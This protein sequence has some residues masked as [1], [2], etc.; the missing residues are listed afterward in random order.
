V[1]RLIIEDFADVSS[2]TPRQ[3]GG[4]P[5]TAISIAAG[6]SVR[7]TG[8]TGPSASANA[9]TAA[10]GNYLERVG[11]PLDLRPFPDLLLW[12]RS[13]RFADGTSGSPL[14]LEVR[15]GSGVPVGDPSN[16]WA[17]LIPIETPGLWQPVPLS[18]ADLPDT[19]RQG[20]TTIRLTCVDA[21]AA[22]QMDIDTI[23]AVHPEVLADVDAAL[24]AR[25]DNRLSLGGAPVPAVVVPVGGAQPSTPVLRIS[26]YDA[27]PDRA[28]SPMDGPRTDFTGTEFALRAPA[29]VYQLDYAIE[30]LA[31]DRASEAAML[32]F[33]L[34]ELT[35]TARLLGAGRTI[36]VEWID[37]PAT[38]AP[39]VVAP[40]PD[41]PVVHVRIWA[42][43]PGAGP[44]Q[45]AVPP[46]NE[47]SVQVDQHA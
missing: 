10:T 40:P 24:L 20:V 11:L 7:L 13:D 37:P 6:G 31:P 33:V 23:L 35:P 41:H 38:A 12:V 42:A 27:R 25:L 39:P 36:R 9:S 47:L 43:Q 46:F 44:A 2:W 18:L 32:A 45:R 15:L 17:R 1:G 21:T 28:M 8:L 5:S 4:A 26:N 16:T 3:P 30:A 14:F 19:V 34:G 29:T 22:W